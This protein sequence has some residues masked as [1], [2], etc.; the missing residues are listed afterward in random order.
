MKHNFWR[1]LVL[2]VLLAG[3]GDLNVTQNPPPEGSGATASLV[4][5]AGASKSFDESASKVMESLPGKLGG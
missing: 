3:C 2:A 5:I 4:E 1:V